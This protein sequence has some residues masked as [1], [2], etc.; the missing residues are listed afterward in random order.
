MMTRDQSAETRE[1]LYTADD[2]RI[3]TFTPGTRSWRWTVRDESDK[4][5]REFASRSGALGT[6]TWDWVKDYV[7]RDDLLLASRQ[8]EGALSTTY[9]YHLDH[10][11]TPRR[12]TD[13]NDNLRGYHDYFA[14]GQESDHHDEP[15]LTPLK[16]TGHERDSGGGVLGPLDYM[17][18]RYY[19]PMLGRFLSIDPI[20][21]TSDNPQSWNRYTYVQNRPL[22]RFDPTGKCGEPF[23]FIGPVLPC[24]VIFD[25]VTVTAK[26]PGMFEHMHWYT[27]E[28]TSQMTQ[29]GPLPYH[30]P[31]LFPWTVWEMYQAKQNPPKDG[32]KIAII[33]IGPTRG[34]TGPGA[35][36]AARFG[37]MW[38]RASLKDAVSTVAGQTPTITQTAQ[39][40][41]FTNPQTGMRVVYDRAGNYF[42]VQ[43][44]QGKYVDQ[45]GKPIPDNVPLV[46]S[47]ASEIGVPRDVRQSLTHFNNVDK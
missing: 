7:W 32:M 16:F 5:L 43:N 28:T 24:V 1:F 12:I 47:K 27:T 18:A 34:P 10:L 37:S 41:I 45:F 23:D 4:V 36:R 17:H 44:P 25:E 40:T 3:G 11:G 15:S 2:Q 22:N 21:G 31:E 9:H 38:T 13:T 39:K 20:Q 14:F 35:W 19:S 6:S 30:S 33:M 42:R 29:F 8:P 46:N 26:D